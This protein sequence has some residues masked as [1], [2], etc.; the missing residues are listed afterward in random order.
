MTLPRS[1]TPSK[2]KWYV[3]SYKQ[4]LAAL[5]LCVLMATA[6]V[7]PTASAY[8]ASQPV[9]PKAPLPGLSPDKQPSAAPIPAD[10]QTLPGP[11][12]ETKT[13]YRPESTRLAA[14][15]VDA[16]AQPSVDEAMRR[17]RAPADPK[18]RIE[19]TNKRTATKEVFRN[20]DGSYTEKHYFAP[21]FYKQDGEW[22]TIDATLVEDKNAGD[23]SNPLGKLYGQAQS[24]FDSEQA[25]TVKA[26]GWQARFAS[27]DHPGGM[28]RVK[29]GSEQVGFT[30]V[31][32]KKVAPVI[33]TDRRGKQV[34]HYYD[35]WPG[36]N[37][38]Y[39]VHSAEIKQNIIL[40]NKDAT[41]EFRYELKGA[42]LKAYPD[43]PGAFTITGAFDNKFAVTPINLLLK[44]AGFVS[45]PVYRQEL[46]G[47]QLRVSV[48]KAYIR[49]LPASEF[50]AVID[51]GTQTQSFVDNYTNFRSDGAVCNSSV[52]NMYAGSLNDGG[53]KSWRVALHVPYGFLNSS[54]IDLWDATLLLEEDGYSS[55]DTFSFQGFYAGCTNN[56]NCASASPAGPSA[57]I[58]AAGELDLTNIYQTLKASNDFNGSVMIRGQECACQSYKSFDPNEAAII[59]SYNRHPAMPGPQVP[60]SDPNT[61]VVTVTTQP[62]I[63]VET[64]TDADGDPVTYSFRVSSNGT[65]LY[66]T[67]WISAN[68][69]TIPDG[70]L[71]DGGAYNWQYA[72]YDGVWASDYANGGKFRVDLRSGKDKTSTYDNL[73][74][75]S[76]SLNNGNAYTAVDSH[77]IKALDGSIGLSLNY[78]S[79][80]AS[81]AGVRAE[82]YN[83][84]SFSGDPSMRRTEAT[85]DNDWRTGS[86]SQNVINPDHFSVRYSGYFIAPETG[87]YYFGASNDDALSVTVNGQV[88]YNS[89]GCSGSTACYGNSI[90]LTAGQTV[91]FKTEYIEDTGNAY[92]RVFVKGAVS[93]EIVR[94]EWL[95]TAPMPTDQASGL[96]GH[97]Y[98]DNGSHDPAQLT[99]KIMTRQDPAVNFLWGNAA[100]IP[101]VQADNFYARWEGYF[102]AATMG[103]YYFGVGS[104]D[105]ARVTVNNGSSPAYSQWAEGAWRTGYDT[106]GIFLSAGQTIPIKMEFFEISGS[107]AAQL[108]VKAPYNT[109][110]AP[111]ESQYLS[112]GGKFLP[113]GWNIS[114][115]ADGN[116]AYERLE[117]RQNGDVIMYDAD[118]STQLFTNTGSGFKP[119]VNEDAYLVRNADGSYNLTDIDGRIYVFNVDGTLR[120]TTAPID[121][122]KPAAIKYNYATQNGMPKLTEIVD[123]VTSARKGSLYYQGDSQCPTPP[124]GFS[125]PPANDLCAF[126]TSDGQRTDFLYSS[127]GRLARVALPGGAAYDMGYEQDTGMLTTIRDV[128]AND[129][130]AA[131]VRADDASTKTEVAY[132]QLKRAASVTAPAPTTGATRSVHS[133]D[134]LPGKS[135]LHISGASEPNGYSQYIEYDNL[136][137]TTKACDVVALCD[138]TDW[139]ATKDLSLSTTD[140]QGLKSTTLYD[141]DDKPTDAYGPAPAAWFGTDRKP[142]T[143]PTDYTTQVPRTETKYDEGITGS[144]VAWHNVKGSVLFGAP[145]LH[146]TGLSSTTPASLIRNFSTTAAP[147][148]PDSGMDGY[149][150]SATGKLRLPGS[151]TYTLRLWHDDG[152]RIWIDDKLVINNWDHRSEGTA[153]TSPSG[154]FVAEAGKVY[155]FRFDYLHVGNPGAIDLWISGA[156]I[157]DTSGQGYGTSAPAFLAADYNLTTTTKTYDAALG[158][159][160]VTT[161]Y[162]TTP[163]LGLAQSTSID[164]TGLN[165]TT[166][167]TYEAPG[168]TDS[169][170]RQTA[171]YLPGANTS[172]TS[173]ATQYSYYGSTETKDNPCTTGTTEAYKQA[174]FLK[175]KIEPDPD[176]TGTQNPRTSETIYDDAGR[177]VASRYNSDDWT[178]TTYDTRGRATGTVVPAFNGNPSRTIT[179][180]YAVSGN[181]LVTSTTDASGTITTEVDL[182]GRTK[183]YIDAYGTWTG[184]EYDSPIGNLTRKFGDMG[185]EVFYYDSYGRL[186]NHL[187]DG[188]TYATVYYDNYSRIDHVDYNNAGSMKLT[189][190]YDTFGRNNTKTYTLGNGTSTIADTVTYSQSG[191]I[192]S[193]TENSL[194]KTYTYDAAD[195][196]TAA[197]IGTNTY[198]YGFGAQNTTTCGTGAGTNANSGKNSNRTTQTINSATTTFCYDYA[199]RLAA[200][201]NS[202]YNNPTYDTHGNMTAIGTG[203]T[204]LYLYYDSSDRNSGFEQYNS[205]GTGTGMYY[206]RDVQGRILARHKNTITTWN[207]AGAGDWYYGFAGAS[208]APDLVRDDNWNV[209]EQYLTLPGGVLLTLRPTESQAN[210]KKTYSLTNI[211]SD[212]MATTNAAGTKTADFWHDPFGNP[213]NGNPNNA[214]P[215]ST[216]GWVGQHQKTQETDFTLQPIQ[217]GVRVYLAQLGRFTSVDSIEGGTENNYVYPTDP[218]NEFD[219]SGTIGFKK[220]FKDRANNIKNG[221]KYV[222][223]K[224]NQ[225]VAWHQKKAPW[226]SDAIGFVAMARGA[227]SFRSAR[228][229]KSPKTTEI[230]GKYQKTSWTVNARNA[231]GAARAVYVKVKDGFGKTIRFYKDTFDVNNKFWHRKDKL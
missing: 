170:L 153:Q 174:G 140:E 106:T 31:G 134:Y 85:V 206:E 12:P 205:S 32:A 28:V 148:T 129:A 74:P 92:A 192:T 168:A 196:L 71:Q 105:G 125:A 143:T 35:L 188:T 173:T 36:V 225:F 138:I 178:C 72:I 163:E 141:D 39:T 166:S 61:E 43:V 222:W 44:N 155:R 118:G 19:Q 130:V 75:V 58:G 98:M 29:Q 25:F 109:N 194:S 218:V 17:S 151:G 7:I 186:S 204:P 197:T 207:W 190:S 89:G 93:E 91:T 49:A 46:I 33:T 88:V 38:E 139:H 179:N 68:R 62:A 145:K 82:Y 8:A 144:A 175:F 201:S 115:D 112:P 217:M 11:L 177:V 104:D 224:R 152:A 117:V 171:K 79:P 180:N 20:T 55:T 124:S 23:S 60:T 9:I 136:L 158:N 90:S 215:A 156:G 18:K 169:F 27:S 160:T 161:N 69:I 200:S 5:F 216:Y 41:T 97:Y 70:L 56:Y 119:P 187:F 191:Q 212:T 210:D 37:V 123:G 94:T 142:L 101:N 227:G 185:E 22:Q 110:G 81:R 132:D 133:L 102:T 77:S 45:E 52:C 184:Y 203:T 51:P 209:V 213:T 162:G 67:D 182:L 149:G 42:N 135:K 193:G 189:P 34:V 107:G 4:R 120:E 57:N 65:M 228:S 111:V 221:G 226:L 2:T 127:T 26:N 96:T 48:D 13:A 172:V 86:P 40:K 231:G 198:S 16:K 146:T 10:K 220:W 1:S 76:V 137:R 116:L 176:G 78:N 211:H 113:S 21:K 24:A 126:I 15:T 99:T 219:L 83:N 73:G 30:P 214:A 122:R 128:L 103:T 80:L 64:T 208:D 165:L 202:L 157:T 230:I 183:T 87:S 50:P 195:R 147:I 84:A 108:L 164:P 159:S 150:F 100:P 54:N 131:A 223:G 14:D 181:P 121:D 199:D 229:Y 95:R 154:T 47:K 6:A 59:F 3:V 63:G 114:A 66:Q 53:W 167:M